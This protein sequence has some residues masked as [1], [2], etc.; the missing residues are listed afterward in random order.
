MAKNYQKGWYDPRNEVACRQ[1]DM[2]MQHL[3][4]MDEWYDWDYE[5]LTEVPQTTT[6]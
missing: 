5:K 2:I 6:Y 1:A 4:A 3:S